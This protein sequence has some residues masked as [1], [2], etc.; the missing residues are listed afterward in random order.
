MTYISIYKLVAYQK[1]K[2][3][4]KTPLSTITRVAYLQGSTMRTTRVDINLGRAISSALEVRE[5]I[6]E[7]IV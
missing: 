2:K 1:K 5:D 4:K 7:V 6:A 3:K